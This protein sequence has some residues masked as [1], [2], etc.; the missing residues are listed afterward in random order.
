MPLISVC[1]AVYNGEAT[2]RE[3]L[4]SVRAQTFEDYELVVLDDGS[5]DRSAEIALEYGA[6]VIRQQNAGLGAGRKR[7]VEEAQGDWIAFIDHDDTWVPDKLEK[8][9]ALASPDVVLIH[10][11]CWYEYEDGRVVERNLHLPSNA[12]SFEHILPSN[13]VIASS[14]VF[15]REAMLEAGNFIAET[16]RC[17]DWYGW[18]ILAPQGRFVHLPEKQVHYKVLST[19]LA[20]AGLKFQTAKRFLLKDIIL[21]RSVEL[22]DEQ[23]RPR[24]EKMIRQ[25][26]GIAASTMAKYLTAEGKKEE[27]KALIKEALALAPTT[28]RVWTRALKSALKR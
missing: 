27:A 15:R 14:A 28:P 7:L 20:N 13:E 23:D 22:F 16:V 11:D 4:D 17:S 9:M 18:F 8:Q 10:S 2:L 1:L 5:S 12:G 6:R 25:D 3:A 19:S 24:Y 21:P 26:I